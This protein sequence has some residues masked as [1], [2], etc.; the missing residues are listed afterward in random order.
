MA[1]ICGN[2]WYDPINKDGTPKGYQLFRECGGEFSW[3]YPEPRVSGRTA[4]AGMAARAGGSVSRKRRGQNLELGPLLDRRLV[5][6]RPLPRRNA[7][8]PDR[9]PRLCGASRLS[10]KRR[11]KLA[12][13]QHPR[14]SDFY[15]KARPSASAQT[16]EVVA[17][18]RFGRRYSER[19][20]L[21]KAQ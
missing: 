6:G 4:T 10:E 13:S 12:K 19:I 15:F 2:L 16:I 17:T 9:R 5:R 3:E 18:D 14:I 20:T 21:E 11:R 8:H 1:Q 7:A